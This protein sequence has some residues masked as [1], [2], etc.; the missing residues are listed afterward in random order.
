MLLASRFIDLLQ[1]SLEYTILAQYAY[2]FD[3]CWRKLEG[4]CAQ[5]VTQPLLLRGGSNRDDILVDTPTQGYLARA[6]SVLLRE[7][8]EDVIRWTTCALC[9]GCER[10]VCRCCNAL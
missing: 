2:L 10:P 7:R 8:I 9:H 3:L 4:H 1:I 5:V 6:Y